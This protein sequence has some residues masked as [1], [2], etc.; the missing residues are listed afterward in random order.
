MH[1]MSRPP[2]GWESRPCQGTP[3]ALWYGPE[4]EFGGVPVET[5]EEREWRERRALDICRTCPFIKRCLDE[6][7][8]FPLTHQWGVRGGMTAEASEVAA[9]LPPG[10]GRADGGGRVMSTKQ[11][12]AAEMQSLLRSMPRYGAPVAERAGWLLRKA[13]LLARIA[14]EESDPRVAK[15]ARGLAAAARQ[16]ARVLTHELLEEIDSPGDLWTGGELR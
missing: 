2:T 5:A 15:N 6:E 16:Q 11:S 10:R 7:L 4:R 13:D 9:P 1:I 8:S 3:T 12:I 14:D